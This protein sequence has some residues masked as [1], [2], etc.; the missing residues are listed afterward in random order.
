MI[1]TKHQ[2]RDGSAGAGVAPRPICVVTRIILKRW[3]YVPFVFFEFVRL[4][5]SA[6][7]IDGFVDA[8][9]AVRRHATVILISLWSDEEPL[10]RFTANGHHTDLARWVRD[11][12]MQVWSG[13]FRLK[14]TSSLSRAWLG[15]VRQW[16]PD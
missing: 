2:E 15:R 8:H 3:R 9:F 13:V 1:V 6:R 14:G 10:V 16:V 12:R 11:Q 4:R 5:G 7:Q